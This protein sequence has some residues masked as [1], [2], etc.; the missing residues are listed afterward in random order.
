M[1][2]RVGIELGVE[3]PGAQ[4]EIQRPEVVVHFRRATECDGDLWRVGVTLFAV[5]TEMIESQ[6]IRCRKLRESQVKIE[7]AR[8]SEQS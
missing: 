7:Q 6:R 2:R 1:L 3:A 5:Q 8:V 4:S